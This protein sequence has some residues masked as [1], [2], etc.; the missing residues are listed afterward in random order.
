MQNYSSIYFNLP[1]LGKQMGKQKIMDQMVGGIPGVQ[2]ALGFLKHKTLICL[3]CS[4]LYELCHT[5]K[6]FLTYFYVMIL[7]CM[8]LMRQEHI[9][10]FSPDLLLDRF[11]LVTNKASVFFFTVWMFLPSKSTLVQT[12]S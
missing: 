9:K 3:G 8:L 4:Q 2:S 12:R 7:S 11:L 10:K 1:I 6:G 5:L